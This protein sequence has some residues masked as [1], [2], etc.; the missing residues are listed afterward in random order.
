MKGLIL[1]YMKHRVTCAP[2]WLPILPHSVVLSWLRV[3]TRTAATSSIAA[4][5]AD[6]TTLLSCLMGVDVAV[7][8]LCGINQPFDT[9][10]ILLGKENAIRKDREENG[11]R[12][13]HHKY[14]CA[15]QGTVLLGAIMLENCVSNNSQ[16]DKECC[17]QSGLYVDILNDWS[18]ELEYALLNAWI[19]VLMKKGVIWSR[20]SASTYTLHRVWSYYAP[21]DGA[22]QVNDDATVDIGSCHDR[23]KSTYPDRMKG[24]QSPMD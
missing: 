7:G 8:E 16:I 20:K 2:I 13:T 23:A 3:A 6:W 21:K 15:C 24:H 18:L 9:W 19:L 17:I 5:A 22:C 10:Y 11:F 1:W 14:Q 12:N 4:G